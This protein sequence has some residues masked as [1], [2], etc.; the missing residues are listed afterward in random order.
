MLDL[1][2]DQNGNV[3]PDFTKAA[4]NLPGCMQY[5]SLVRDCIELFAHQNL[6]GLPLDITQ[7]S[8]VSHSAPPGEYQYADYGA[9]HQKG[10][11]LSKLYSPRQGKSI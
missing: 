9:V 8:H 7:N 6:P 3:L 11:L 10:E 4:N 5:I 2:T 1:Y